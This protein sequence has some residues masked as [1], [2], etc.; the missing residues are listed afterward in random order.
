MFSHL[1]ESDVHTGELKRRGTFF[2]LTLAAYA[3]L[4]MAGGVAGVYAYQAHIEDQNLELVALVPP[5]MEERKPSEPPTIRREYTPAP[6]NTS[7]V[8]NTG[9]F[10]RTPPSN[11]SPDPT[12]ISGAAQGSTTQ[13]PPEIQ[14][15]GNRSYS[16]DSGV[17]NPNGDPNSSSS[18]ST[19][20]NRGGGTIDEP[21]PATPRKPPE[22]KQKTIVSLGVITSQAISKPEPIYPPL[23]KAA[24]VEGTVTVEILIDETGHVLTAHATNGHPLLKQEAERAALRTRFSP[25]LLSNQAVKAKGVITFNFILRR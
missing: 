5:E 12:K 19:G 4:F 13:M 22:A 17:F 9:G 7:G 25:T 6:A 20:G 18:N 16:V 3:L 10:V 8:R 11:T 21:P 23:A 1:V 14:S 24:G 15:G 2:L